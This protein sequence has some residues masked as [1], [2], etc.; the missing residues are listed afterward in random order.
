[1]RR[2]FETIIRIGFVGGHTK[3]HGLGLLLADP[4]QEISQAGANVVMQIRR[5]LK[6]IGLFLREWSSW[7]VKLGG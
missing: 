1:L 2:D 7:A 5:R 3:A 4:F 6:A